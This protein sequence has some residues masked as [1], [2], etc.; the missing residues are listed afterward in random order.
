MDFSTKNI[1]K[2][3][4]EVL[5]HI[6]TWMNLEIILEKSMRK[7]DMTYNSRVWGPGRMGMTPMCIE[8][9]LGS[10]DNVLKWVVIITAQ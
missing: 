5:T 2:E 6:A 9:Y 7:E 8:F 10:E 4:N 3:R 1:K